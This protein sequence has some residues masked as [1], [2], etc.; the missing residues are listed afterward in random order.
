MNVFSLI[1]VKAY[2][3]FDINGKIVAKGEFKQGNFYIIN[4]SLLTNGVYFVHVVSEN[5]VKTSFKILKE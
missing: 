1:P 2:E 5:N 3:I 4:T